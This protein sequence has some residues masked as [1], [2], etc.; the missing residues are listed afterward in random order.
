MFSKSSNYITSQEVPP[1]INIQ[2]ISKWSIMVVMINGKIS[3]WIP[4]TF[5]LSWKHKTGH[6]FMYTFLSY[7]RSLVQHFFILS[8]PWTWHLLTGHHLWWMQCVGASL[9]AYHLLHCLLPCPCSWHQVF[10]WGFLITRVII[11]APLS[12]FSVL[13]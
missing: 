3:L 12:I 2:E 4:H 7:C 8:S 1:S 10:W 6:W 9:Y 13:K 11:M 5:S